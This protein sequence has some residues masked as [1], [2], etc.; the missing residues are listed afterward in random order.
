MEL[1]LLQ[2]YYERNQR[3]FK[4][5][6]EASLQELRDKNNE[7]LSAVIAEACEEAKELLERSNKKAFERFEK[8]QAEVERMVKENYSGMILTPYVKSI[9]EDLES[10]LR[11]NQRLFNQSIAYYKN[12]SKS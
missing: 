9:Q 4:A 3:E 11:F 6:C 8:S 12:L 7:Y 5:Q 2:E 10:S 1:H